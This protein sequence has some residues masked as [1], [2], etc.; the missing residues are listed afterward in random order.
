M[1]LSRSI[2]D[3]L[4]PDPTRPFDIVGAILS[5][6]GLVV[7]VMGILAADKNVAIAVVL[8][9][10]GSS[11]IGGFFVWVRAR[12]A[13]RYGTPVVDQALP[14][15]HIEPR[16]RDPKRSVV[17]AHGNFVRCVRLSPGHQG[18]Q[19]DSNGSDLHRSD[20]WHPCLVARRRPSRQAVPTAS[21]HFHWVRDDY[22]RRRF[23]PCDRE[24]FPQCLVLCPWIVT[25]RVGPWCDADPVGQYR[26]ICVSRD[27]ARRDLGTLSECVQSRIVPRHSDRRHHTGLQVSPPRRSPTPSQ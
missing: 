9:A 14:Q 5:A 4:P 15:P 22:R 21:A 17:D 12:G 11:V 20:P 2:H 19:R 10:L 1:V 8:L 24:A 23:P 25:Y 26:A 27:T 6:T 13:S 16:P 3:P 18:V 7:L